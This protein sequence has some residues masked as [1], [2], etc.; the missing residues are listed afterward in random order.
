MTCEDRIKHVHRKL[1]MTS[2]SFGVRK[3]KSFCLTLSH[4]MKAKLTVMK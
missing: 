4:M 1:N 2:L 3:K